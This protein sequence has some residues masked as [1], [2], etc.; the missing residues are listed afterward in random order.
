MS[1][2]SKVLYALQQIDARLAR[3][4]RRYREVQEQLGESEVLVEARTAHIE[5]DAQLSAARGRLRDHE[6]EAE[7][8]AQKFR[9]TEERLYSGRIRNPKELSDLQHESEYLKRRRSVLEEHV[10]EEMMAVERLASQ[11]KAAA[12]RFAAVEAA[13]R[14][15]NADLSAEYDVLRQELTELLGKRNSLA[16]YVNE[17]DMAEYDALRR[18]RGGIAVVAVRDDTCQV[19]HVQVP[20]RDVERARDGDTFMYCSGCE[21]ILYV[22]E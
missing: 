9:E 13:W 3:E 7:G 4:K 12:E 2:R 17:T 21:R 6:L 1:K 16:Q 20:M 5:A 14:S 19:C 22:P 15:E 18:L 10:L 8:A 11:A